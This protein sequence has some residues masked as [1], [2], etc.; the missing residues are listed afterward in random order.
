[1]FCWKLGDLCFCF[2]Y[3]LEAIIFYHHSAYKTAS[4]AHYAAQGFHIKKKKTSIV[5][6]NLHTID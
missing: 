6:V 3:K 5:K 2:A 1:M 4:I